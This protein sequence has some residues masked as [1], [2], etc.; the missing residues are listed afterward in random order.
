LQQPY[1]PPAAARPASSQPPDGK[2]EE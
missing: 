1:E 2:K